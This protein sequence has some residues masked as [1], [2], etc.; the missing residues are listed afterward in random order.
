MKGEFDVLVAIIIY[1]GVMAYWGESYLPTS[2]LKYG[3][4][5]DSIGQSLGL[6]SGDKILLVNGKVPE[7]FKNISK[8]IIFS[9][10][11]KIE[12][13]RDGQRVTIDVPA[14]AVGTILK[15][16]GQDLSSR[17]SHLLS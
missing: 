12:V 17:A 9:G 14:A 10:V 13:E 8:D 2:S 11:Q 16:K 5:V 7:K 15:V 3:I 1:T 6:R 4:A